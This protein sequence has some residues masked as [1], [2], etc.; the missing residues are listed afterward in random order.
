MFRQVGVF[1]SSKS[2]MKTSAP[3]FSA[4]MTILRS[5]GPVSSTHRRWRSLGAGAT[6]QAPSRIPRVS[7]RKSSRPP[8]SNAAWRSARRRRSAVRVAPSSRW[9]SATNASAAGV[10]ISANRPS[11]GPSSPMPSAF[12]IGPSSAARASRQ[13]APRIGDRLPPAARASSYYAARRRERGARSSP[14]NSATTGLW[15]LSPAQREPLTTRQDTRRAAHVAW[16]RRCRRSG[17]ARAGR[18]STG[19]S[20]RAGA[21]DWRPASSSRGRTPRPAGPG[22]PARRGSSGSALPAALAD[23]RR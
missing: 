22:S 2:A 13:P 19:G 6:V 8:A 5:A 4:L 16:A 1:A 7:G 3:E 15:S 14:V 23:D 20:A 10:R 9:S 18:R 11:I 17:T 21:R 12:A